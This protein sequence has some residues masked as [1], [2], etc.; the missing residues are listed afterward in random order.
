MV[1][2]DGF[3]LSSRNSL[4]KATNDAH[5]LSAAAIID[6]QAGYSTVWT[7]SRGFNRATEVR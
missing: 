4:N 3:E 1:G 2:W 7:S 6:R 5:L